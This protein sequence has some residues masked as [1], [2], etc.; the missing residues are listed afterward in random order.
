MGDKTQIA[1]VAL[2]VRYMDIVSV[3]LG[4]TLGMMLANMPAVF[5]GN[6]IAKNFSLQLARASNRC[7]DLCHPRRADA[8]QR[9]QVFLRDPYLHAS[10]P[11]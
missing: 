8:G 3:V 7:R 2:A 9:G 4:T 11:N 6:K 5:L 1:T 10:M